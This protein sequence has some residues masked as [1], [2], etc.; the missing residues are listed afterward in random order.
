[1]ASAAFAS[2]FPDLWRLNIHSPASTRS[3]IVL[4]FTSSLLAMMNFLDREGVTTRAIT[5]LAAI[6]M[7]ASIHETPFQIRLRYCGV[8]LPVA[9]HCGQHLQRDIHSPG[10]HEIE[11][12]DC[13]HATRAGVDVDRLLNRAI[14][15]D[16]RRAIGAQDR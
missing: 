9:A 5:S 12:L 15:D 2:R 14:G 10:V 7:H 6:S 8:L 4:S 3:A 1:M 16:D 13:V 11:L